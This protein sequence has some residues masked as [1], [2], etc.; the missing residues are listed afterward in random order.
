MP[1][2]IATIACFRTFL[3]TLIID[4]HVHHRGGVVPH[5]LPVPSI[6]FVTRS[7]LVA[8]LVGPPQ[9]VSC[10][11]GNGFGE[12]PSSTALLFFD[13]GLEKTAS[14]TAPL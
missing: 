1:V 12:W 5:N 6:F 4:P 14:Y 13:D 7:N 9:L 11:K 2:L 10:S 8:S 3:C